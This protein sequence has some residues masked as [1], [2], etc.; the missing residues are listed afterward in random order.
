[1]SSRTR[2]VGAVHGADAIVVAAG[3]STRMGGTDKLAARVGDRPLLAWTLDAWL[4]R[5]ASP[6]WSW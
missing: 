6:G 4:A 1:V 5:R 3:A 2:P